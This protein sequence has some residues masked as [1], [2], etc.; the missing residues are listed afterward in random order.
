MNHPETDTRNRNIMVAV[1]FIFFCIG[2][3]SLIVQLVGVQFFFM[4]WMDAFGPL[5]S[6]IIKLVMILGGMTLVVAAKSSDDAFDE[7]LQ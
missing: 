2:V 3:L 5:V 7:D 6:F 1:G 4:K